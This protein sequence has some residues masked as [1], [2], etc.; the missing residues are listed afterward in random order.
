[1]DGRDVQSLPSPENLRHAAVLKL[2]HW[3]ISL[4]NAH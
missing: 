3:V 2:R 1:M 4:I